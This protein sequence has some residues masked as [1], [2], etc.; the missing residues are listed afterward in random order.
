MGKKLAS[1][2]HSM[3][4]EDYQ[5]RENMLDPRRVDFSGMT[6]LSEADW[7]EEDPSAHNSGPI[8]R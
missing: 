6:Y 5:D 8:I 7:Q 2:H 3:S 4:V 1:D